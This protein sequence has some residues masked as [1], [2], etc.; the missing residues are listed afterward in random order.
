M[1]LMLKFILHYHKVTSEFV[2]VILDDVTCTK[3][4]ILFQKTP[5]Y[6]NINNGLPATTIFSL[7]KSLVD[8]LFVIYNYFVIHSLIQICFVISDGVHG[9]GPPPNFE[10]VSHGW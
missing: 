1:I 9:G 2:C 6:Y 10:K 5:F 7:Y 3:S 4:L 8:P